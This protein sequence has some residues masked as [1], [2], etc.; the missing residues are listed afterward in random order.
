MNDKL[1]DMDNLIPLQVR[2]IVDKIAF[3]STDGTE[4]QQI[5]DDLNN[6]DIEIDGLRKIKEIPIDSNGVFS[7]RTYRFKQF[8]KETI[9]NRECQN[10]LIDNKCPVN[11]LL[12]IT[13]KGTKRIITIES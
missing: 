1:K 4:S 13:S 2:K 10:Y 9:P 7:F 11:V 8:D 6:I 5:E 12:N 3:N